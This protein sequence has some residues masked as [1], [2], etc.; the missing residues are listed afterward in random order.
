[1]V[2]GLLP[3][4]RGGLGELAKTGQHSRFIEGYLK[5]Y[6]RAFEQ[7]R[8]FSYLSESLAD[9]TTDA[10]L[11]ARVRLLPGGGW[12]PWLYAFVMPFRYRRQLC[13]CTVL[14]VFQVTGAIPAILAKRLF[15]IPFVA[16]YGYQY[17]KFE[18]RSTASRWLRRGVEAI[19]LA[20]ADAVIVP[21]PEL[22]AHVAGKVAEA[23]V[24]LIPNGVDTT[25]FR[26]LARKPGPIKKVLYVGR[27]V[28][29]KNLETLIMAAAKLIGR[30]SLRLTF[31]GDGPLH[32][33]LEASAKRLRVPVEFLPFVDHRELPRFFAE[34]DAFV[35]PSFIEGHAKVLLEAMSCGVP[36]IAS[37]VEGNSASLADGEAGLLFDPAD[38][39]ALADRLQRVFTQEELARGLG[40]RARARIR[41][42]YDLGRL[43]GQEIELLRR[44]GSA[45][46]AASARGQL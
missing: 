15:G 46:A 16:T 21:N 10:E 44:V 2:L 41:E 33:R 3:S 36:C 11:L 39:N 37:D 7:V 43:V 22:A 24:H 14:R 30:F 4:I 31:I 20:A 9:Y 17:S 1:M 19:G 45:R 27:L 34:A 28:R 13:G 5:L 12:H 40:E 18:A 29:Q 38:P 35:L 42:S 32:D 23:K 6:A 25:L 8:Y 26:P